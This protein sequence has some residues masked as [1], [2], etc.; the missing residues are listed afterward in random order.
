MARL[1]LSMLALCLFL[2]VFATAL[3]TA[4]NNRPDPNAWAFHMAEEMADSAAPT[5]SNARVHAP[6]SSSAT[7]SKASASA[8]ATPSS[9]ATPAPPQE[10]ISGGKSKSAFDSIPLLGPLLGSLLGS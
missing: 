8:S 5:P 7:P 10:T 9:S 6:A 2:A 4:Q 1:S 3:P